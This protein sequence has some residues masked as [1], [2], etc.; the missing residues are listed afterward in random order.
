MAS[1]RDRL[2]PSDVIKAAFEVS[3]ETKQEVF[4]VGGTVRDLLMKS[5]L[6]NDFDF[7]AEG[8][9]IAFAK[10][11]AYKVNGSFFVLDEE[12]DTARVVSKMGFQAD[13]SGVRGSIDED[14]RSR[15]FTINSMAIP[16]D[17][18]FESQ[19]SIILDPLE[20]KNDIE[21]RLLRASSQNS[22]QEDPLRIMRAFRFSSSLD[23]AIDE[24]LSSQIKRHCEDLNRVSEERVR[25]E[26]F[27]ILE[28]PAAYKTL[29]GM[30]EAGV[31]KSL[32]PEVEKWKGF[33]Q[34]G[35]HIHDLFDHSMKTVDTAEEVLSNLNSYFPKHGKEI[36]NYMAE[37]IEAYV[38]RKGL[39]KVASLLHDSGKFYTRIMEEGKG[40]FLGHEGVG[41]GITT[42]ISKGLKLSRRSEMILRGLTAN[43]MRVLALSKLKKVTKRAEYR[44][45]RDAAGFN[46]D[47]LLLSLADATATPIEGERFEELKRLVQGL[48]DY[49]FDE[50]ITVPSAPLLTGEDIMK[51]FGIPQGKK[52]GELLEMLR[53]AEIMGKVSNK[54]ESVAYLKKMFL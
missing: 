7:V 51:L 38:T 39:L 50:F 16:L 33:Y 23:F 20:G 5:M 4:L 11:F 22:I 28:T 26:L 15:D 30:D 29:K 47:L 35:W 37:E 44:F 32:F 42:D 36:E 21:S 3:K 41:D 53:E 17:S 27:M 10:L 34:G 31:L 19:V 12:R 13:F 6:G 48:A 24:G 25:A 1:L 52:V 2:I 43:H 49:Y 14:L 8:K 46:L 40:R 45:F 9:G 54:R 18:I